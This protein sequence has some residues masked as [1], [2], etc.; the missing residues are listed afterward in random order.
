MFFRPS[1]DVFNGL[2]EWTKVAEFTAYTVVM[3]AGGEALSTMMWAAKVNSLVGVTEANNVV[4]ATN[5]V[6]QTANSAATVSRH[7]NN[8]LNKTL[9]K[10]QIQKLVDI[11][12]LAESSLKKGQFRMDALMDILLENGVSAEE[13][14]KMLSPLRGGWKIIK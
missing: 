3:A 8:I 5:K 2:K 11:E 10:E 9:T 6:V 12:N 13:A 4:Q 1:E 14:F 7:A